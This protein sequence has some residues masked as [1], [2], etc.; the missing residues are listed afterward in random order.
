M[1]SPDDD[2]QMNV[3]DKE[4][5]LKSLLAEYGT[6]ALAY[7]GGVDSTYLAALAH[8]V[9]GD[10]LLL[11]LNDTPSMPRWELENA[12]EL[13]RS[14]GWHV[15]RIHTSEFED[16]AYLANDAMRCYRCKTGL[17][18]RMWACARKQGFTVLSPWREC[19]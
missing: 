18:Q 7:S 12:L 2:A 11:I 5:R 10:K 19:G 13:A 9:L 16:D 6:L 3:V 4:A 8:E 17:F 14:H 15:E 1:T